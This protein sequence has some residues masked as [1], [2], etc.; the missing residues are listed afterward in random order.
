[1]KKITF[2]LIFGLCLIFSAQVISQNHKSNI[3]NHFDQLLEQNELLIED[4]QWLINSE[5]ISST[6][7][8]QHVYF[9]QIVN[10]IEIY[11]TQ[12]S[13]HIL[14]SGKTLSA[15]S[16][17]I[18]DSK[19]KVLNDTP[20]LTATQALISAANQLNYNISESI[21][22]INSGNSTN[23]K[24]I[25]T[26]AGISL[27]NIPAKLVYHIS[28]ENE[29][30]LAWDISI[31]EISQQD[32]WSI[33]VDA[34][35]GAILNKNNWMVSCSF[36]HDHSTDNEL[37][38]NS[39]LF[40]IPNYN[41]IYEEN[42][43]CTTCYEVI[44]MP[45]ESPY[46]GARSI[47]SGIENATA[48]PFGWHDTN[49]AAG[50][51]FTVTKGNNVDA[52]EDGNNPGY[53]PDG[54][55]NLDFTGYP[56]SQI[57]TGAN[58]YEDAAITNLFYWNNI[59]HD[60]MYTY[61]FDEASG[62]FQE[63]NY[64]NGGN[65][66]DSV[67]AEAQDGS[68]TCNANFGTPGD[69]GNPTMQM[70]VCG[71]KD[72]DFDNLV[73]VH[74]YGHGISNRLTGG[75][76]NSGCLNNSEQMGEGWSD[77]YGVMMTI[78]TGDSGTDA[79]GVGTYLFGQGAGGAG[80]RNFKYSTDMAV[81]PHTYD[82]IKTTGSSPHALGEVWA[83]MLWELNWALIDDHGFDT[84]IY[85]F[86]GDSNLDAGN[87][88]AMALVTE[89][90]RLQPCSP[91]FVDGRDAIL[92]ADAAIYGGANECLIWEA[93]AKRGLGLSADQGSSGSRSDGTEAF[94]TPTGVAGFTAPEDVCSSASIL[95]GLSGGSPSGGVYSGNGV[96]DDGNGS[97][98]SFDPSVAGVGVH[99]ITYDVEAGTCSTASAASDTIEVIA[100]PTGPATTGASDFCIGEEITVTATLSDPSNVI[101]WYDAET[102]GNLL[103]E[104]ESYTFI[105]AGNMNVYAQESTAGPLSKLVISEINLEAP[106]QLEIQNVG[107]AFDYTGYSVALSQDPYPDVNAINTIVQ[108]LGAMGTDSVVDWNDNG[109]ADYWGNNIYW[110]PTG[111]GW[112]IIIDDVGNVVDSVFWNFTAAQISG[113]NITI[114]GFNITAANLDWIGDGANLTNVCTGSFRRIGDT[115]SSADWSGSCETSDFGTPNDEIALGSSGCQGERT[116]TEVAADLI[117]PTISCSID[118]EISADVNNCFA[119][120]ISLIDP[121][122]SDN[123][124]VSTVTNDAPSSFPI[125]FTNV[126]WTVTDTAGNTNTCTQVVT[127]IDDIDPLISCIPN[128]EISTDV[129]SCMAT[130]VIL[131]NPTNSDN[132]GVQSLTNNAPTNLPI[133]DTTVIWTITDTAGNTNTCSQIVTVIDDIDP[134]ISCSLDIEVNVDEDSCSASGVILNDPTTSDNC[135]IQSLTNNAPPIFSLG[136]TTVIWIVTDTAGNT[137]T[138]SQIVTVIDD[139]APEISCSENIIVFVDED[140]CAA[141]GIVLIDP[142]TSDNC[143]VQSVTNNAPPVYPLG[144]TNV[145]W[146]ITDN[147]G[148]TNT[149][150]QVVTVLDD[151]DPEIICPDD[152]IE[153]VNEGELYTIPDY[154]SD[155]TATDNCTTNPTIT[156]DP[157]AGTEVGVGVT[158]ISLTVTD[159]SGNTMTCTFDLTIDEILGTN[160]LEFS[161]SIV[162]YPN[163]ANQEVYLVNN[164]DKQLLVA[165]IIDVSG[166]I[167]QK[168]DMSN[169][170]IETKIQIDNYSNGVYFVRINSENATIIKRFVKH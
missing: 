126:I 119:S 104:G 40:D 20:S 84:D 142:V 55:A 29:L 12:S 98:Y 8:I 154:T 41:E 10:G 46:F 123:C 105:P 58:Q 107:Q 66:S 112:I 42:G 80:I 158:V 147:S 44:A 152:I 77:F 74:E 17:F 135:N 59:I 68:G 15:D 79:R 18:K 106:D 148:I 128:I 94:D 39:N 45:I 168:V 100:S 151:I 90:L 2:I 166:R 37:N 86:T 43:G 122:S 30:K 141:S 54:G 69:G 96:I 150:I 159:G 149:C 67:N 139:I 163:P 136:D 165:T 138:C 34:N 92:A 82:D 85:N 114:N 32:W 103:F 146:T 143:G 65:G 129:D 109:G 111:T 49:G 124:G 113:L 9:T 22:V 28:S 16:K 108:S 91:G 137:N 93:F 110:D 3:T 57:Y 162:L 25:L 157:V 117:L 70:Y 11:G 50:A 24:T 31:Q 160:D 116:I 101:R 48:S 140:Q 125:G 81:N 26:N 52:Y 169:S 167:I 131:D 35:S 161:N 153:T 72:G 88:V 78:E 132:C 62:N 120:G 6:S 75:P 134:L 38:Y 5:N 53:Q 1:M 19:R 87:V 156:Q 115:D 33:R 145:T 102:G 133:G 51:E 170:G 36:E 155:A 27:S 61:G 13:I 127:V 71:D 64:G 23:K 95:T 121:T 118:I 21:S 73:I 99:T 89:G 63:N 4:V 83:T 7:N 14:P 130:G 164:S 60:V 47:E 56:F 144:V 76:S 97:T